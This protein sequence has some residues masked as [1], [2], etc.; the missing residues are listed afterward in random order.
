MAFQEVSTQGWGGRIVSSFG[1][2]L[3]GVVLFIVSFP[4]LFWNEGRAVHMAQDLE[5]GAKSVVHMEAD[6]VDP[7]N[8]NKLIHIQCHGEHR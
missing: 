3:L 7:A 1:G 6:K 8:D 2:A 4:V 5:E